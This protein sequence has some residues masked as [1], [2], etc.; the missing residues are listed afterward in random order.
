MFG[1][2]EEEEEEE[3]GDGE[4]G[5]AGERGRSVRRSGG[6]RGCGVPRG[7]LIPPWSPR[8]STMVE[9]E[10]LKMKARLQL[11]LGVPS[12]THLERGGDR[13]TQGSEVRPES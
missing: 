3:G 9:G 7:V 10:G 1:E 2:E 4:V 13:G 5:G 11:P 6:R 8:V 12:L